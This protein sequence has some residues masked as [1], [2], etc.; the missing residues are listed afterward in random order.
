MENEE[1][2]AGEPGLDAQQQNTRDIRRTAAA[3]KDTPLRV[4]TEPLLAVDDFDDEAPHYQEQPHDID[5]RPRWRR[6]HVSDC[7]DCG[8]IGLL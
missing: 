6:P 8:S 2:F 4:H 5:T 3:L 1:L 7:L